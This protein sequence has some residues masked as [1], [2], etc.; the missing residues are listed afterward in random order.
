MTSTA[1]SMFYLL[2]HVIA[3][4]CKPNIS[5]LIKMAKIMKIR[6]NC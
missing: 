6:I 3:Y 4:R 5:G 2:K 1:L